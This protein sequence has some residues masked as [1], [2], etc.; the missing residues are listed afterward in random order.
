MENIVKGKYGNGTLEISSGKMAKQANGS[1]VVKYNDNMVLVTAVVSNEKKD[2]DFFPLTVDYREKAFATGKIPG[3]FIKREGRPKDRE[4]LTSRLIDR[5]IRPLFPDDFLYETQ[6]V[7]TLL[8][9]DG[10]IDTDVLAVI[11]ASAALSISDIP[12]EGPVGAARVAMINGEFIANPNFED[13]EDADLELVVAGTETTV[14]TIEASANEVSEDEMLRAIEFGHTLIKQSIELQKELIAKNEIKKM[15]Y[16][17]YSIPDDLKQ[18]VLS[19]VDENEIEKINSISLKQERTKT[20]KK[21]VKSIIEKL[22][23]E[24]PDSNRIIAGIIDDITK[25]IMRRN[26]I[27]KG[28]R[29]DGRGFTDIRNISCEVGILPRT[30]GS[31]LFTRGETQSIAG[32][33]LGTSSDEQIIEE[34]MGET[35]KTFMLHYNFPPY[36]VGEVGFMRGPGRREIGHGYLAEKA[37]QAIIPSEEIFPYTIRIVSEILESNG[38]SSMASVCSGSLSLM[39]AGVPVKSHV[40]GIA[41]GLITDGNSTIILSDIMGEEDHYGDMDFKV[42]GTR[43]G[44]TALQLDT[45]VQGISMEILQKGF[46]QAKQGREF[47]LGKMEEVISQPRNSLSEYAPRLVSFMIDKDKIGLVIGPG[48]KSIRSIIEKTGVKIDIAEDGKVTIASTDE[49]GLLEAKKIIDDLTKDVQ[50]GEV[51]KGK[52]TKITNFGAFIELLPGK[53]GMMHISQYSYDRIKS[54]DDYLKVGDIVE[55][56]VN[57][58]DSNGRVNLSRKALLPKPEYKKHFNKKHETKN[59]DQ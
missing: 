52:V 58:I 36:S 22:E 39:D 20:Y 6:I 2:N 51:Y 17:P 16:E 54:L 37:L 9:A 47:I 12:F 3:G 26:I 31:A 44:I 23:E 49:K 18:K 21:Y 4:I 34:L 50:V 24:Y 48:G 30:H 43:E 35:S 40:A 10:K 59:K 38:S 13:A 28:K 1:V 7:A 25:K 8:S 53:E 29:L 57:E 45:K 5:P 41:M 33:T 19:I 32:L 56:K 14:T 55:V 15:E 46:M 42:A 11:G 27:E